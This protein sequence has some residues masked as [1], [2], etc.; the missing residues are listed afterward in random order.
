MSWDIHFW[1]GSESSQDEAGA[2][3]I[4][5]V[6]LDDALGGA[7]EQHREVQDHESAKF[8]SYFEKGTK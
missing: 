8:L 5:S 1:I 6:Q 2:A 4:L 3:A 7:P